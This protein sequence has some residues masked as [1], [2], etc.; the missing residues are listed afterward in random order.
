MMGCNVIVIGAG[1]SGLCF[2]RAGRQRLA[3]RPGGGVDRRCVRE[4]RNDRRARIRPISRA[5]R[6]LLQV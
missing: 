1:P 3:A 6:S 4:L 2:A 5:M